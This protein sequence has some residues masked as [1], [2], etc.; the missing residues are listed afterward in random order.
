M[1]GV[2]MARWSR[3]YRMKLAVLAGALGAFGQAPFDVP[4]A[5][6]L[7]LTFGFMLWRSEQTRPAE[8]GWTFGLGYF[9]L[10]LV[11]ILQPFQVD[12]ER[13]GWMAPFALVF[14]SGGLALFWAAAFWLARRLS[15]RG[16]VLVVTWTGAELLR[17][18]IFTGFP[19]A[20][21]AQAMIH[22]PAAILMAWGGPHLA[23][24]VILCL[25]A[26]VSAPARAG[27]RTQMRAGQACLF[28]AGT[29]ALSLPLAR[30]PSEMTNH[31]VRLVQPNIAQHLKWN[32]ELAGSF[33]E[34][35]IALTSSPA[36]GRTDPPA[37]VVW[38][39]TAIPWLLDSAGSILP[40]IADASDGVPVAL[41]TLRYDGD[42]LRNSMA[43]IG[44]GGIVQ[45]VYD[46]H[47]LVPFGEYIPFRSLAERLG[48]Q[49]LAAS[50]GGFSKGPGP[51][52]ID[53]GPLG[54]G[55]PLVCYEAVFAHE[56]NASPERPDFLLQITNDAWFGTYAGPQQH[57]AQ[58][59]M[60]AIEQGVP[61]MRSA[62]TGISAMIDPAGRILAQLAMNEEGVLD[63]S[64]PASLPAT[65]YSRTGDWPVIGLVL[66]G[67]VASLRGTGPR[68]RKLND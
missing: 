48:L 39:E 45:A 7:S 18:Y 27:R 44:S 8:L 36:M 11:W 29:L 22:G 46:K 68:R 31:W 64:L 65:I 47:H 5:T 12:P 40:R 56:V 30:A 19:W 41:G 34:R 2:R 1:T 3:L 57:L 16:W 14:L 32:P 60:R 33:F 43:V 20:N 9:A 61:V 25:A 17:A 10:T 54:R 67:L 52:L 55:L 13:H 50:M 15:A 21:P 6:L 28:V 53:F 59:R 23:T 26:V 35:Q 66:L 49:A 37:L 58:A 4:V 62:N 38:P 51:R 24:L 42:L 63:V